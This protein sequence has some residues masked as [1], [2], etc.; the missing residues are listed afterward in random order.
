MLWCYLSKT[1]L[2][3]RGNNISTGFEME[4]F[5]MITRR[6]EV[7]FFTTNMKMYAIIFIKGSCIVFGTLVLCIFP[8]KVDLRK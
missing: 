3:Q 5:I 6:Y 2:F 8:S 1:T 7:V 4:L